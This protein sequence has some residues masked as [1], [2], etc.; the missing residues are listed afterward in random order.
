MAVS[1]EV[2]RQGGGT[3]EQ[4][5][6]AERAFLYVRNAGIVIAL[7]ALI[8]ELNSLLVPGLFLAGAGEVGRRTV[9]K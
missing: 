6:F 2:F 8:P 7:A 9:K 1:A 4:K 5:S 3:K